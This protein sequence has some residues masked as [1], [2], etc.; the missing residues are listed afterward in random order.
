MSPSE[1]EKS[2]RYIRQLFMLFD[3]MSISK[4]DPGGLLAFVPKEN[5]KQENQ[6]YN[7]LNRQGAKVARKAKLESCRI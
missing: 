4:S 3:G 1:N 5:T 6:K 7:P 2:W